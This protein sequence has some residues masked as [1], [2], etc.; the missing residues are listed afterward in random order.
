MSIATAENG[1]VNTAEGQNPAVIAKA[2][3]IL[4]GNIY[5]TLSTSSRSG[6]PWA[7]P[8]FFTYDS[9]W[10]L[11]WSS[12]VVAQHSQ[13]L[14]DNQGRAAIAIYSTDREEGQGQGLY[15]S[16]TAGEVEPENVERVIPLLLK[17]A[18]KGQQ[19]SPADY[20]TP[21]PRRLYRFQPQ[22]VWI[23]GGRIALSET[24]LIDTK[25]QLNLASLIARP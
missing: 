6:V 20:L 24:V 13:N 8:I 7:S 9:N 14:Y 18:A 22:M 19:R 5:G 10:N 15:L 12:T 4:E 11:Y 23:T 3:Q 25:I 21:S 17:R 2:R 16:G 1:W